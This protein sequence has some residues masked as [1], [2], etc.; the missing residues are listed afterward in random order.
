MVDALAQ[1]RSL[2]NLDFTLAAINYL[3]LHESLVTRLNL[4]KLTSVVD[5]TLKFDGPNSN[6]D[7][8]PILGRLP[9][10]IRRLALSDIGPFCTDYD[11]LCPAAA[12]YLP[13]YAPLYTGQ[14]SEPSPHTTLPQNPK[15]DVLP[16]SQQL[17]SLLLARTR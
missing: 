16:V 2:T 11:T 10:S 13:K 4:G 15:P 12:H 14:A 1:Q 3:H 8:A 7:I 6:I 9:P 5:S 17:Q